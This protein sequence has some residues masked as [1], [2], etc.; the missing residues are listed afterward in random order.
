MGDR[1]GPAAMSRVFILH[2]LR[3][4][5]AT[6]AAFIGPAEGVWLWGLG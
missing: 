5:A 3:A 1:F 2:Y 4:K 6:D